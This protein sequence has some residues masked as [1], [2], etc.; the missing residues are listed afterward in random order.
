MG[1]TYYYLKPYSNFKFLQNVLYFYTKY[2]N[3]MEKLVSD[4]RKFPNMYCIPLSKSYNVNEIETLKS[5]T[6][7]RMYWYKGRETNR[8]RDDSRYHDVNLHSY[9]NGYGTIEIRSHGGT[10]D[11]DK[12]LLWVR[13]HQTILDKLQNMDIEDI[14]KYPDG[15]C[16]FIDFVND[17]LLSKYIKR[18]LGY[19]SN[20]KRI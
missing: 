11:A 1:Y 10:I 2:S 6:E 14:K 13:L 8:K 9:F 4:S 17:D 20:I 16:G 3:V 7:L 18:L 15:Y 5:E 12:I 19:F